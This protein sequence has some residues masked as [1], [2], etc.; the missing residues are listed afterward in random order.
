MCL[1]AAQPPWSD[2]STDEKTVL[3]RTGHTVEEVQRL[4]D[5]CKEDLI[6]YRARVR[7]SGPA[8]DRPYPSPIN[9]LAITLYYVRLYPT[10]EYLAEEFQMSHQ[11]MHHMVHKVIDSLFLYAVP[12]LISVPNLSDP[13][14]P[15]GKHFSWKLITDTTFVAVYE[16]EKLEERSKYFHSK[17]ATN[18]SFKFQVTADFNHLIVHVSNVYPGSVHDSTIYR[19]SSIMDYI[20]TWKKVVG[21][22]AYIGCPFIVTP[23]KNPPH[24]ELTAEQ[25]EHNRKVASDRAAIENIIE[26]IKHYKIISTIYRG[27][28]EDLHTMTQICHVIC[29]LTNLNLERSPIRATGL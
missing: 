17:S 28:I 1:F 4:Y 29:A 22:K 5:L 14:T 16:P 6:N 11:Y 24:G 13:N 21:D 23:H 27:K 9:M 10:E 12:D 3:Q 19:E 25:Q 26:R 8:R 20:G 2:W 15:H 7:G 18:Y